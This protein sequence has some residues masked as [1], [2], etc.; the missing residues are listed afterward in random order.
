[1]HKA[2]DRGVRADSKREHENGS[3]GEARRLDQLTTRES[4]IMNHNF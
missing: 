2:K 3:N 4:K 1:V